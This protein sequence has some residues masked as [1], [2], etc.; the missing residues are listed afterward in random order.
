MAEDRPKRPTF[1]PNEVRDISEAVYRARLDED[2]VGNV[3]R[4][5]EKDQDGGKRLRNRAAAYDPLTRAYL[6]ILAD[7]TPPR[8]E[9]RS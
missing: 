7:R 3:A 8:K 1:D 4:M 6:E 9:V 2:C 5:L